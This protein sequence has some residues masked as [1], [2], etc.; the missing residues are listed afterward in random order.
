ME[1]FNFRTIT[2]VLSFPREQAGEGASFPLM[3]DSSAHGGSGG[4]SLVRVEFVDLGRGKLPGVDLLLKQDV[5]FTVRPAL[6]FRQTEPN[7]DDL[8]RR[9]VSICPQSRETSTYGEESTNTPNVTALGA[10]VPFSRVEHVR[11]QDTNHKTAQVV[12]VSGQDDRLCSQSGRRH[13]GDQ[14][15]TDGADGKIYIR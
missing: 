14:R 7:P 1:Y 9:R 5:K 4:V 10:Q 3:N 11:V 8:K 13:L 12:Q 15:V 6:G 2:Q